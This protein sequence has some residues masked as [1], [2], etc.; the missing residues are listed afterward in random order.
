M[1]GGVLPRLRLQLPAG[2]RPGRQAARPARP[3]PGADRRDPLTAMND[4]TGEELLET[5]F[6]ERESGRDAEETTLA[7]AG[8][9][10]TGRGT[11]DVAEL[12]AMGLVRRDGARVAVAEEGGRR[13]RA[14]VRRHRL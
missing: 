1:P 8:E 12:Q 7:H 5:V 4:R 10:A 14:V 3:P 9:H 11:A 13:A 6:T 2:D